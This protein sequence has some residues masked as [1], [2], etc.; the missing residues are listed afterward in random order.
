MIMSRRA[1]H[2]TR[3]F[4]RLFPSPCPSRFPS[5]PSRAEKLF[6][7]Q[8]DKTKQNKIDVQS[9]AKSASVLN[10]LRIQTRPPCQ[11]A[12][13]ISLYARAISP[14]ILYYVPLSQLYITIL[15]DSR[16][17]VVI[18]NY[19][20]GIYSPKTF[21]EIETKRNRDIIFKAIKGQ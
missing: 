5:C 9:L 18:I 15:E 19:Y 6:Y 1:V 20:K 12:S 14:V 11:D 21:Y 8:V 7:M 17:R 3:L 10:T 13:L 16:N 4:M 2:C